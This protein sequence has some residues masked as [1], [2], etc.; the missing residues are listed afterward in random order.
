MREEWK[1][2]GWEEEMMGGMVVGKEGGSGREE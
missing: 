1:K 2:G